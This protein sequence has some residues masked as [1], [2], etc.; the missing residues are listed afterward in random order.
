[1]AFSADI[2]A[3]INASALK[4]YINKREVLSQNIQNKPMLSAFNRRFGRFS[5]GNGLIVSRAVDAGQGGL[6]L[7]G[8][9]G[10]DQ[11]SYGNPTGTKR[12][13]YTAKEHHIGVVVTMSELKEDGIEVIENGADQETSNVSGREEHALVDI[14]ETKYR[15]LDEDYDVSLDLLLHGDGSSDP[16]AL[17]GIRSLILDNPLTGTTGGIN[18]ALFPWWRNRAATA[19]YGGAGGQGAITSSATNGGA[20]IAFLDKEIRQLKRYNSGRTNW[21]WFAGSDWI[22]A[23]KLELRANGNTAQDWAFNDGVPDGSMKDPRHAGNTI[24]Y[25]PV[26]DDLGLSKRCY[27]IAM[28]EDDIQLKYFNGKKKTQHNPARPYDRYVMYNGVTTTAV[29][30]AFRLRTSAVYDIA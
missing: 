18:R 1:M 25:D 7:Q 29:L 26:M 21:M 10:D 5:G 15:R 16:K 11:V 4:N 30:T 13:E 20:L 8:F 24:V 12:A 6:S 23:Y 2:I 3:D 22:D 9:K 17:A 14:L 28:G 27:V 19:A